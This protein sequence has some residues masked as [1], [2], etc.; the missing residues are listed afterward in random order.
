MSAGDGNWRLAVVIPTYDRADLLRRSIDSV[1][2][3]ER[4]ADQILVVDDGSGDDTAAIVTGYGAA[5]TYVPKK[6]GGVA[7]AR[8]L[9]V[10]RSEADFIAFLDSD[11]YWD[12]GHLRQI[13]AAIESTRGEAWI[14][15]SDLRLGDQDTADSIWQACEFEIR[16]GFEFREDGGEWVL[17]H[18]QPMMTPATVVRRDAY[19]AVGGQ[20]ENL[21]CREDTHLFLKLGLAGAMNA[22]SGVAGEATG[23][24]P[25]RLSERHKGRD[26]MYWRC[27]RW[28]YADILNRYP[29]LPPERRGI[30][31]RRLAD[32]HWTLGRISL[33]RPVASF[34][35]VA[36]AARTDRRTAAERFR[37]W[38]A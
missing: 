20:A 18:R 12:E 7:S 32:A 3:Q 19:L 8:N 1:L 9:G 13:E 23:D 4:P 16:G 28:L 22:V 34:A 6:R 29:N 25:N 5:V 35:Q 36:R 2:R 10:A 24:D 33:R 31:R 37:A 15:F 17:L 14:Y 30:L 38:G 11:D 26:L 27:T 21:T